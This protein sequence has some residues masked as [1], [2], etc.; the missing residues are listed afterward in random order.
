MTAVN[1][2]SPVLYNDQQTAQKPL[3][4]RRPD[5]GIDLIGYFIASLDTSGNTQLPCNQTPL[6]VDLTAS[7]LARLDCTL[8]TYVGR[9][10]DDALLEYHTMLVLK[11]YADT[12]A[13]WRLEWLG[14][15]NDGASGPIYPTAPN[16]NSATSN[17]IKQRKPFVESTLTGGNGYPKMSTSTLPDQLYRVHRVQ[18]TY[19][20]L[21]LTNCV[22]GP[23]LLV[24]TLAMGSTKASPQNVSLG[25]WGSA[26]VSLHPEAGAADYPLEIHAKVANGSAGTPRFRVFT[27]NPAGV[28]T[29]IPPCK[30]GKFGSEQCPLSPNKTID[31]TVDIKS[32][33]SVDEVLLV[34]SNTTEPAEFS[35]RFGPSTSKLSIV[36][37]KTGSPANIGDYG[38]GATPTT[39]PFTL[40]F[41]ATDANNQPV[42]TV[43]GKNLQISVAGSPLD[44]S[45]CDISGGPNCPFTLFAMSGGAYMAVVDVPDNLYPAA[46]GG[47]LDLTIASAGLT[48]DTQA[49]ALEVTAAPRS[50]A[51]AF[52]VDT[53]GSMNNFGKLE[54]VKKALKLIVDGMSEDD[55]AGL[56]IFSTHSLTVEPMGLLGSGTKRQDMVNAID[57]MAPGGSTA[58]GNGL[59]RGQDELATLLDG[60]MLPGDPEPAMVLLTDGLSNCN[61]TSKTYAY[62]NKSKDADLVLGP[63]DCSINTVPTF[64]PWPSDQSSAPYQKARL[65]FFDRRDNNPKLSTPRISVIGV[66]QDADM[67]SIDFLAGISGG[68]RFYVP[69]PAPEDL[70]TLGIS[71]AFR[72][73][74]N[75]TSGHQRVL[76]TTTSSITS[77]P[78]FSVD[79]STTELLV[80]LLSVSSADPADAVTLLT[81]SGSMIAPVSASPERAVFRVVNPQPGTWEFSVAPGVPG[82][83]GSDPVVFVEAA[84]R[85]GCRLIARVDVRGSELASPT[86]PD[87]EDEKWVGR[88]LLLQAVL[89]DSTGSLPAAIDAEIQ[90]PDLTFDNVVLFDDGRHDDGAPGDGV[91]GAAYTQTSSAGNYRVRLM[92]SGPGGACVREHS[93][94]VAL[95]NAPDLDG[96]D[97]PDWWQTQHGLPSGSAMLDPDR[98]EVINIDEFLAGTNPLVADTDGGGESDYSEILTGRDPRERGDDTIGKPEL[99]ALPL[100]AAVAL[101]PGVPF[102]AGYEL[103]VHRGP[104]PSGPFVLE[105]SFTTDWGSEIV[106]SATND[107]KHCYTARLIG[108][109]ATS[110]WASPVCATPAPDPVPPKFKLIY[111]EGSR[112]CARKPIATVRIEA[113]DAGYSPYLL[114]PEIDNTQPSGMSEMLVTSD[115]NPVGQWQPFEPTFTID[116]GAALHATATI[117]VR[118]AAGNE[119]EDSIQIVR[120]RSSVIDEAIFMEEQALALLAAGD[121]NAA[122]AL[123]QQSLPLIE[124]S[125]ATVHARVSGGPDPKKSTDAHLMAKLKQVSSNKK[126]VLQS[127]G[128]KALEHATTALEQALELEYEL[129]ELASEEIRAL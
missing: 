88:D 20:C 42:D 84:V 90:R 44:T 106:L 23:N 18:D 30:V 43:N 34:A 49:Q 105:Q 108:P 128:P 110:G 12:D 15:Y 59:F 62:T 120:C 69:N 109:V 127:N 72:N 74:T 4:E 114:S 27:I 53:S 29:L 68:L 89:R 77:L 124:T 45:M 51:Q 99:I 21:D 33:G 67:S 116:L 8:E 36:S 117:R 123:V 38:S 94:M 129:T 76:G 79:A 58:I 41:T 2:V 85:A 6:G 57:S 121:L 73:A 28:P 52:V 56:V 9:N 40:Y 3:N 115:F 96:D 60:V 1:S 86:N 35:W 66:G 19:T 112:G 63:V 25:K 111:V 17:A 39:K 54:A 100:N 37:P 82:S 78:T 95:R 126:K 46:P 102:V 87:F 32:D 101:Q 75:A 26:Y 16:P 98:D 119:N 47:R 71:S 22:P 50:I 48:P 5:E 81:P 122:R 80:S 7:V 70:L 13:R 97:L 125:I 31:V 61:W 93:D 107:V 65:A 104:T 113:E 83:A 55:Y 10:F 91:F 24:N 11:D 118:D 14:D 103:E 64:A 92:A